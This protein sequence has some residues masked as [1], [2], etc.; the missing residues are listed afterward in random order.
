[1]RVAAVYILAS[2]RNGTLYCGSTWNLV[3]RV[4]EHKQGL[5]SRFA[6]RYSVHVLVWYELHAEISAAY[7]RE[8]QIKEWKRAWKLALIERDNPGW[9]DLYDDLLE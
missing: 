2:Q 7:L 8:R 5:G 6:A 9:R 4:W 1:M 3:R